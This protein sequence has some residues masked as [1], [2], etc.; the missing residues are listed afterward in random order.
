MSAIG[1]SGD[2]NI[3]SGKAA[4]NDGGSIVLSSGISKESS[5]GMI[6]MKSGVSK[7]SGVSGSLIVASSTGMISGKIVM[8]TGHS[9]KN[10]E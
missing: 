1:G 10:Y 2:L 4:K 3:L 7:A 6:S 8:R 9:F 5:G